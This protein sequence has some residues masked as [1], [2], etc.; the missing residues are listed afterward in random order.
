MSGAIGKILT[1]ETGTNVTD[2][3]GVG[4]E[5]DAVAQIP[6]AAR[7]WL[8]FYTMDLFPYQPGGNGHLRA[9]DLGYR[10]LPTDEPGVIVYPALLETAFEIDRRVGLDPGTASD[11][12]AT[13][14]SVRLNNLAR[15]YDD[16]TLTRNS[17]TRLLRVQV[18]Q[19]RF[20]RTR[21]IYVDPSY[22]DL[23]TLFAGYAMP[24]RLSEEQL[25][26]PLR[27]ATYLA[28][29]PIQASLY[30]GAGGAG[31]GPELTGKP[32]PMVRGG[33]PDVPVKNVPLVT[34]DAVNLIYQ[35]TDA[36]G[37]VAALY[38]G[39]AAVFNYA[40]DVAD[41]WSG[42][43]PAPGYYRTNNANGRLQ[44]GSKPV[45]T[46]TA[47][48]TGAFPVAGVKTTAASIAQYV[49]SETMAQPTS[50]ID[51]V[52][53]AAVDVSYPYAAGFYVGP[54]ETR[55]LDVLN[56]LAASVGGRLIPARNGALQL[57]LVQQIPFGAVPEAVL[58]TANVISVTPQPLSRNLDPPPSL[59]KVGYGLNNTVQTAGLNPTVPVARMSEIANSYQYSTWSDP[60]I[61][62]V[63]PSSNK[64]PPVATLLLQPFD[65]QAVANELG[66][67][68]RDRPGCYAVEI[69]MDIAV[70]LDIGSIV[71]LTWP[72]GNLSTGQLGQIVGE[73][74]RSYDA[75]ATFIVLASTPRSTNPFTVG[76]ST[77]GGTDVLL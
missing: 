52:S 35:W 54:V 2:Q 66:A 7:S 40:G 50:M 56:L 36:A 55:A 72:L 60:T 38:E 43:P 67:L 18:G 17:D 63:Y 27:D 26:I 42:T 71:K 24:W 73:Q 22:S 13:F 4:L 9:S 68:W 59:W 70:T 69:P 74:I 49:L 44:M 41:L 75:S 64:P 76:T 10:S 5:Y 30:T 3:A 21:G 6:L 65:A 33:T 8:I 53:F 34:V 51:L 58:S 62:T 47:D 37:T 32:I 11:A 25:E 31:G 16:F 46:L 57:F 48:V 61:N 14:G 23:G 39:G 29:R 12:T 20:D 19:K 1:T 77:A 15:L 28:D 45:N